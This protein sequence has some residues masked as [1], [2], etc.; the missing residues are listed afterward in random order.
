MNSYNDNL[1]ADVLASLQSQ[2][3]DQKKKN[4][5]QN[6]AMFSLY[7]AQGARITAA[8]KLESAEADLKAKE[9]WKTKR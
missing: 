2:E 1:H 6:A 7:Y 8:D 3:L 5:Q 9:R 4:A